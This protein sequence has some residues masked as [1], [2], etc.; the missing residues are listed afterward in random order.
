MNQEM[1]A[2]IGDEAELLWQAGATFASE[3]IVDPTKYPGE[4]RWQF[5][6]GVHWRL[7]ELWADWGAP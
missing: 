4:Q 6:Q 1:M 3:S 2:D 7:Q 5:V